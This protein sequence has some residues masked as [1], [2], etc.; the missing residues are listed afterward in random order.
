MISY[1]RLESLRL[2]QFAFYVQRQQMQMFSTDLCRLVYY[3]HTVT[4]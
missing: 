2:V 4:S 3:D 1:K